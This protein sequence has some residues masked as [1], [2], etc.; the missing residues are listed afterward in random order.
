MRIPR[1]YQATAN[2]WVVG[3]QI[4]LEADAANHVGRVL[5]MS[6]GQQLE[7]FNGDGSNYAATITE[8]TKRAVQVKIDAVTTNVSESAVHIHLAQGISRGDRMDFV[9]QKSVELGVAE[10][11]PLFTERCGVKLSGERLLKK[12]QQ[13]Q[14]IVIAACEQSGRS[15]VP[16]VHTPVSFSQWLQQLPSGLRL[17][18][19]P[20]AQKPLRDLA[21]QPQQLTL[22]IGPEGGL[23]E[24]EVVSASEHG[25]LPV[26][27]GPR[28]LRTETAALTALSIIQYQFGDL[29]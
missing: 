18:L 1:I 10:I 15:R 3:A 8:A 22:F 5:R 20:Y 23:S 11:T 2:P 9:L 16:M 7:L 25:F 24:Q 12:Q 27:L 26:R 17:T 29:A 21:E 19:D 4:E 6:A 14:K 28:I 13:W